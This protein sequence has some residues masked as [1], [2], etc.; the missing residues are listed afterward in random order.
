[1]HKVD[2]NNEIDEKAL[3]K[4]TIVRWKRIIIIEDEDNWWFQGWSSGE[5]NQ[6]YLI[7]PSWLG[8]IYPHSPQP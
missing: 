3:S 7:S 6:V 4:M 5:L 2:P 8:R 1:M